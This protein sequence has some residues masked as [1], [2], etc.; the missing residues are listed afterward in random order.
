MAKCVQLQETSF[1]TIKSS[2][3]PVAKF[4]KLQEVSFKTATF[5]VCGYMYA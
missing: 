2:I 3:H 1:K 5:C 4:E